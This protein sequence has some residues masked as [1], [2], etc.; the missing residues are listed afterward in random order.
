MPRDFIT[1]IL[2]AEGGYT[3]HP[4][5]WGGP[6]NFGITRATLSWWLGHLATIED[7]Q[8][9]TID[10]ARKI[11]QALYVEAPGFDK[12]TAPEYLKAQLIDYGVNS[13]PS[14]AISK[15]QTILGIQADGIIGP[16]TI[17][18]LAAAEPRE[19]NNRLVVA[20]LQ[21]IGRLIS[22]SKSQAAFASGWI[23][24]ACG[25]FIP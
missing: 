5:D 21:M 8:S 4:D 22:R 23:N 14:L 20:R 24:R 7:V 19:I 13:G 17:A 1:D 15:L 18:A 9:L 12:L 25:F 16:L 2:K 3:D 6:T 11:Y 10:R